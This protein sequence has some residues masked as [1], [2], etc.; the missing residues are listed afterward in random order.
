M[1]V[2]FFFFIQ[3]YN[4]KIKGTL[5][6][7]FQRILCSIG[8][9]SVDIYLGER[10]LSSKVAFVNLHPRGGPHLVAYI[11]QNYFDS[12]GCSPPQKLS[13]FIIKPNVHCLF[14]G[15]KIQSLT[16]KMVC[17]CAAFCSYYFF[18]KSLRNR[19]PLCCFRFILTKFFFT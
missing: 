13:R 18:D 1:I 5:N 3:K 6:I 14:A 19:F 8:L 15:Y 10:Q 12:Y 7:K 11:N 4:L 2:S 9:D 17:F 16:S